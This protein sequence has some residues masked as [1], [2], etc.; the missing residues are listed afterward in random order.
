MKALVYNGARDVSISEV[1]DAQIEHP[2][3]VVIQLTTTNICGS[4]L[5]MSGTRTSAR[6]S[7][8]ATRSRT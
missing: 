7:P 3:D 8:S 6:S 2:T 4:D 5:H 1:P